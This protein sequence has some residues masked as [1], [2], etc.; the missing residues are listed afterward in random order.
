MSP[1]QLTITQ[2]LDKL[3]KNEFS[4]VELTQACLDRIEQTDTKLKAFITVTKDEALKVAKNADEIYQKQPE[5]INDY[6]LLGVPVSIKDL[7]STK[8]ILTS[9]GSNILKNYIPPYD[10]TVVKK[11]KNAG[12][13]IIGKTNL[14]A[15]AHGSS[16]EASDF[17]TTLNPWNLEYLPGGSSGGSAA[18]VISDQTIFSIGTE[19]GGSIRQP[20]AW[21]GIVG[22]KP[23]Y[24]R[25]SRYGVIAMASSLDSPGPMCK[26]VEDTAIVLNVLA[27][28]DPLDST[29][30]SVPL[31]DYTAALNQNLKGLTIGYCEKYLNKPVQPAV[32]QAIRDA[33]KTFSGL[34]ANIKTIELMDPK[35]AVAVYTVLQRAE[36]SSNLARYDGIRYGHSVLRN[37]KYQP[38]D[39]IDVY[40][41][42]RAAGFGEEAK[43]RIMLGTYTLSAGYYDAYYLK[44]QKARTKICR[45]F[46]K[47]FDKVNLIV[48]PTS[49]ST[50]QKVGARNKNPMFGEMEDIL[51]EPSTIAGLP[52]INLPCGFGN[53]LPIGLQIIGP[54][55]KENKIIQAAYAYE[56]ATDWHKKRPKIASVAG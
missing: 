20:A 24:G 53:N 54:Q 34:G 29:S 25:V 6:P 49:P 22:L 43:R 16:T 52:G 23:T 47:A 18:S 44:A 28:H 21:C 41:E 56:Q 48:G 40:N 37:K 2:A 38:E 8:G 30:S 55:F 7:Y 35:Y 27:G 46:E 14:D 13:V 45:D 26:T 50:A 39:I 19:T 17:F 9:A 4:S 15:F 51:V 31:V 33:L 36:V 12:A 10:A 32:A 1:N 11:L 3:R 42:T 5:K